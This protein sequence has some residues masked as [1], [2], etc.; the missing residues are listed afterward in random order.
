MAGERDRIEEFWR[1]FATHNIE[2]SRLGNT[3]EPFWDLALERLKKVDEHF[4]FE[5]SRERDPA[6][7]FIV[8]AEGHIASFPTAEELVRLAPSIEGWTFIA[9]KPAQGFRFTTD[10]E[11]TRF[12]PRQMWF[13]P[14][15]S[16]SRPG[17]LGI[18][19]A[20]PGLDGIDKT[21][22]HTAVLVILDTG[23]GE[24]SAALDLQYTEVTDVPADPASEGYIELPELADY[25]AWRKKRLR[26]S[27]V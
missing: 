22:A 4:W 5:L 17:D 25:I 2:F 27:P 20:I 10:Y 3:D 8:T 16:K 15:E 14:L 23:L 18:R 24:R 9:L 11:G 6:R 7:E 19:I 21:L 26:S 12:D 1:W 13:L